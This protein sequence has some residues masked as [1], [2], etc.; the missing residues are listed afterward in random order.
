MNRQELEQALKGMTE[1]EFS[2]F[3]KD[4]GGG[5]GTY[6]GIVRAYVDNPNLEGRLCQ[7]LK[8][9]TEDERRT[10]AALDAVRSSKRSATAAVIS[11]IIAIL[12]LLVTIILQ[13]R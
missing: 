1:D 2:K 7:L 4:F 9:P 8:I 13:L 3:S 12:S 5:H 11:A 6:E 10:K